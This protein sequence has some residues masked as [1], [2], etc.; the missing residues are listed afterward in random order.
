MGDR[1]KAI[2]FFNQAVKS[3]N[4][5]GSDNPDRLKHSYQL[6]SSACL[7]DPTWGDSHYQ[8]GN[9]NSDL[10]HLPAAIACWRRALQCDVAPDLRAKAMSNLGWRLHC[11]GQTQEALAILKESAALDPNNSLTWVNL[12]C[13]YQ[14]LGDAPPMLEAAEMA[15][16]LEPTN[17]VVEVA[18]AFAH[19]YSRNLATGLKHFEARYA[20]KLKSYLQFPYPKW[21]GQDGGTVYLDADQGLGDTLSFARFVPLAAKRAKY[22][23][24]CVQ[25][26]LYHLFLHS[27]VG[28]P[29][30]NV[31]PKPCGFLPADHWTT[32]VSLPF[33]LG[34]TDKEIRE[35][36]GIAVPNVRIPVN[37]KQPD[38]KLHI[39]IAWE[40]SDLNNINRHRSIPVE[41]FFDLY[42]VPGVQLYALQ[43]DGK[44]QQ[45][46]DKG[47]LALIVDLARYINNVT[48]TIAVLR[49]M[50]LV[51]T[52]E[53]AL[54]HISG[55]IQKETWLPYS[56]LG[57]DYR[58]GMLGDDCF[59]YSKH[60]IFK[61]G[62]DLQWQPVFDQI[63]E[64][65]KEKVG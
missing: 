19:L 5:T 7:T 59:W 28:I 20:Y 13:V 24:A 36:P 4:D 33:A 48:D 30:V 37:W 25:P 35:T 21:E 41:Q 46:Y 2:E 43:C 60:R 8:A 64:A 45:M 16:A 44:R 38:R 11:L 65:L 62:F 63:V 31:V 9:N 50:D 10:E 42:R 61:Q 18:Y 1:Q 34:L 58:L 57:V 40:G 29:N 6:F 27:F 32:F 53:S 3:V 26:E 39:A 23:H 22:I 55:L 54:A 12:S 14:V 47:G 17:P 56:R 15:Y 52:C 49:E 51:I